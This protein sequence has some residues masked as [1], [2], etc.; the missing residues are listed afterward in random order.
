MAHELLGVIFCPVWNS[1]E[2]L[3]L[4]KYVVK[5]KMIGLTFNLSFKIKSQEL[6]VTLGSTL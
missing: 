3:L 6:D 5:C 4:I 1:K 2:H